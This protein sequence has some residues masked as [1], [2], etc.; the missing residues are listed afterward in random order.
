M[1]V[2]VLVVMTRTQAEAEHATAT[3]LG[4]IL[5]LAVAL[6]SDQGRTHFVLQVVLVVLAGDGRGDPVYLRVEVKSV[7]GGGPGFFVGGGGETS[8]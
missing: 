5:R 6:G 3:D 1:I 4:L 7:E 8:S 2:L